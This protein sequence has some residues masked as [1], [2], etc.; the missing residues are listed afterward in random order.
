MAAKALLECRERPRRG[1]DTRT[2]Q[3]Y[4]GHKNIQHTVRYTELAPTRFRNLWT[5]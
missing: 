3:A 4:L 2:Q 5:D 1:T